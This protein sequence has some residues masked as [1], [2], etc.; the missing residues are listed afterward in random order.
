MNVYNRDT[1]VYT[2]VSTFFKTSENGRKTEVFILKELH[3][4]ENELK[5]DL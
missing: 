3:I 4:K 2:Q 5:K 1:K